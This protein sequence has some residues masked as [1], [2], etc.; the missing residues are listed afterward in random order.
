LNKAQIKGFLEYDGVED[1]NEL[2]ADVED[3]GEWIGNL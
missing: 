1:D 3:L 2:Y